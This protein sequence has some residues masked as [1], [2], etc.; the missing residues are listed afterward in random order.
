MYI[1]V[2]NAE[3]TTP[4]GDYVNFYA[5]RRTTDSIDSRGIITRDEP[6]SDASISAARFYKCSNAM[7]HAVAR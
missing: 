3:C 6:V 1:R 7:T 5:R 4:T 2:T